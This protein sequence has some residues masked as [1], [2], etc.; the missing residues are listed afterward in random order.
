MATL[1]HCQGRPSSHSSGQYQVGVSYRTHPSSSG[2]TSKQALDKLLL[3]TASTKHPYQ[4][5]RES[6]WEFH[7]VTRFV[8]ILRGFTVWDVLLKKERWLLKGSFIY[9]ASKKRQDSHPKLCLPEGRLSHCLY[10]STLFGLCS[11]LH[12]S[13]WVPVKPILFKAASAKYSATF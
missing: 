8:T 3:P 7:W 11:W 1:L 5:E 6:L 9:L 4:S 12:S 10:A 2:D 13:C